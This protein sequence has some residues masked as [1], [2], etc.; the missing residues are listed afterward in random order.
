MLLSGRSLRFQILV[1]ITGILIIPIL[2]MVYDLIYASKTDQMLLVHKEERLA[3]VV[4]FL[5]AGVK[6]EAL[7]DGDAAIPPDRLRQAFEQV[8]APLAERYEGVRLGLYIPATDQ[9]V[10]E[11]FLH[12]Y[13]QLTPEERK[14]REQRIL[15]EAS[16]GI[17]AVMA[18]KEPLA[19]IA[20]TPDDQFFEH[21][22]PLE[23]RGQVV[24]VV[25]AEER[26]NPIFT[27]SRNFRL[28]TRYLTLLGF[29]F[30]TIGTLM[31]ILNLTSRV[32]AI[33]Q[34]LARLESDI[35]RLLPPMPGEMGQIVQAI[36]K[37]AL[38]LAEKERLETELRR[39]ERLAALGRL[40]TGIAHE[41]R[42][43]I[44]IVKA[45]VQVME[46]ELQH[47]PEVQDYARVIKEQVNRQN[48]VLQEL[49]EFGRPSPGIVQP[50]NVNRLVESVLTFAQPLL[51]QQGI[52]LQLSLS[53]KLPPVQGDGEKLKQVFLNLILNAVQAM[54]TGGML[55]IETGGNG[56]VFVRFTD[57]GAG[58]EPDDIPHLFEPYYTTKKNG[59]G[60]GLAITHRIVELHGGHIE[61]ESE[62]GRGARFTVYLPATEAGERTPEAGTDR[63]KEER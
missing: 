35:H 3:A 56:E 20:G 19:R 25:W 40:V 34:G 32:G 54:P 22:V 57:T 15:R 63:E 31:V 9:I 2:V 16:S 52:A 49:L 6:S 24:G 10:V 17:N 29:F 47:V 5:A 61:V 18:S 38:G 48:H 36:N 39:A 37:M 45:A 11:G 4:Q 60:L 41:L 13:R 53:E 44:A 55:V 62:P 27:Q 46:K 7:I 12:E 21:L 23:A 42:N 58:I 50:L 26:I 8:A 59:S 33:K 43:P 28:V 1:I 51:R 30:G 14:A